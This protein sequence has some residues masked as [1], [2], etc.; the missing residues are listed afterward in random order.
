MIFR[1]FGIITHII[2]SDH[3]K[4]DTSVAI[5]PKFVIES[6]QSHQEIADGFNQVLKQTDPPCRGLVHDQYV[7]LHP[8]S[9]DLHYWSPQL[10]LYM[11]EEEDGVTVIHGRFGPQP[12][13][14]TMFIF[15]YSII[16]A[17]ALIVTVIG[18]A[19]LSIDLSG[20][21]LWLLPVLIVM[22]LSLY[23]VA[24]LGQKKG[25]DQMVALQEVLERVIVEKE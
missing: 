6:G 21:I 13:V 2:M 5:R 4:I 3:L 16:G 25:H 12:G 15:F 22:F 10:S 17:A 19:N 7:T 1:S 18:F 11:E 9:E 14:W 23:L 20:A 24:F 8:R